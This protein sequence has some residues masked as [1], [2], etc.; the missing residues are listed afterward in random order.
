MKLTGVRVRLLR[1]HRVQGLLVL[2]TA[3]LAFWSL[4]SFAATSTQTRAA[5]QDQGTGLVPAFPGAEGFGA[6]AKGGRGGAVCEVTNLNDSGA[7]SLRNCIDAQG[8]RIVVFRLGGTILLKT[9]LVIRNPYITIAGQSATGGGIALRGGHLRIATHDVVVR[10]LRVR[11]GPDVQKPDIGDG[12]ELLSGSHNVIVDHCSVS[13]ATDENMSMWGNGQ[14][15]DSISDITFQWNIDAEALY[16]STHPKGCHSMGMLV[17][18]GA[19]R[20]SIHHNLLAH[21][22]ERNPILIAGEADFVDNV[23]YDY[24]DTMRLNTEGVIPIKANVVDNYFKLGPQTPRD[25]E[26]RVTDEYLDSGSMLYFLGNRAL[27]DR[28]TKTRDAV[29]SCGSGV[30]SWTVPTRLNYPS[31]T[32]ASAEEAFKQVLANAGATLPVRDD[33]D[34]RIVKEVATG[35]GHIINDPSEVGGWPVLKSDPPLPDSDHDG[36]PDDWELKYKLNPSL[37]ADARLDAD[38][39]GYTNVEEYLNGTNPLQADV[40]GSQA[41]GQLW[42]LVLGL[43]PLGAAVAVIVWKR[44]GTADE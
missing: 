1:R 42:V 8:P 36:M 24:R 5:A 11:P 33:A 3:C 35:T 14:E 43:I 15:A 28:A 23:I 21:N 30:C 40:I 27:D 12:I 13:W 20:V 38:G 44:H 41:H 26:I 2:A 19:T 4:V 39:D 34:Q 16:C 17:K 9:P 6:Y 25:W 18:N 37:S 29:V 10:Y 22:V 31:I 7:G 32:T